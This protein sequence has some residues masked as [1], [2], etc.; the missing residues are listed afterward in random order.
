MGF[1]LL[2]F[3]IAVMAVG[4]RVALAQSVGFGTELGTGFGAEARA[5]GTPLSSSTF[6]TYL[7]TTARERSTQ[8][9]IAES[10]MT[11]TTL[12]VGEGQPATGAG[13]GNDLNFQLRLVHSVRFG[14]HCSTTAAISSFLSTLRT[15]PYWTALCWS[16]NWCRMAGLS[17]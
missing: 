13:V 8:R 2:L 16:W 15:R 4:G 14:S 6:G 12:S 1:G 10:L 5:T 7:A 3:F 11:G 17:V 9:L